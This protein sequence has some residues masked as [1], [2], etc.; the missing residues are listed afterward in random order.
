MVVELSQVTAMYELTILQVLF[1][2]AFSWLHSVDN[3]VEEDRTHGK[4]L[5]LRVARMH[6][7]ARTHTHTHT[8]TH[9]QGLT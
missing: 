5:E 2:L 8:H 9:T 7:R 4:Q 6:A 1:L 3:S